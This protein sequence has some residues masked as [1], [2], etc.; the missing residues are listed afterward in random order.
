MDDHI[1]LCLPTAASLQLYAA[2]Q[3]YISINQ[4]VSCLLL[5]ACLSMSDS[6]SRW[7]EGLL[8]RIRPF[9]SSEFQAQAVT[10]SPAFLRLLEMCVWVIHMT[11]CAMLWLDALSNNPALYPCDFDGLIWY[12]SASLKTASHKVF[13]QQKFCFFKTGQVGLSIKSLVYF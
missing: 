10:L 2:A 7:K 11:L 4:N 13:W 9:S 6:I 1:C 3:A 12:I 8:Q 5:V